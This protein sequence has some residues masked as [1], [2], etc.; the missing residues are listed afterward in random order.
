MHHEFH[1]GVVIVQQRHLVQRRRFDRLPLQ[2]LFG[3]LLGCH[4]PILMLSMLMHYVNIRAFTFVFHLTRFPVDAQ[5]APGIVK[6]R[7]AFSQSVEILA[8]PIQNRLTWIFFQAVCLKQTSFLKNFVTPGQ[9]CKFKTRV[10]GL[11]ML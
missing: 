4:T 6:S 2:Q 5:M 11:Y 3:I 1:R 7:V 9:K 10:K 8:I